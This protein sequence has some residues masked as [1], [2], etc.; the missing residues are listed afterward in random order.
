MKNAIW[1]GGEEIFNMDKVKAALNKVWEADYTQVAPSFA[2][3]RL[4]MF[5]SVFMNIFS[6]DLNASDDS[7]EGSTKRKKQHAQ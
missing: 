3:K 4:Q 6:V 2:V 7:S 5:S 1:R